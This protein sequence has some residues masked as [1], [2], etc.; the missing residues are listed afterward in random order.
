MRETCVLQYLCIQKTVRHRTGA[1][2][3]RRRNRRWC[4]NRRRNPYIRVLDTI[5]KIKSQ[6]IPA[7]GRPGLQPGKG[8]P[9]AVQALLKQRLS[10]SDFCNNT[11]YPAP[12]HLNTVLHKAPCCKFM[13]QTRCRQSDNIVV[14][15]PD[16]PDE[17]TES[18][19]NSIGPRLIIGF[20]Q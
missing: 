19:L 6:I 5:I 15:S 20:F 3:N 14:I 12:L 9:A 7:A 18:S 11:R 2:R 10:S 1:A 16:S 4:R 13:I 17:D 8:S